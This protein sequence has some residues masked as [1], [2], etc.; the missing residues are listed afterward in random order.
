MVR[1]M[2]FQLP[3]M[4]FGR[5][6][7]R[8]SDP[9]LATDSDFNVIGHIDFIK[10]DGISGWISGWVKKREHDASL[11]I[12]LFIKGRSVHKNYLANL[13][14]IDL[15]EAE[16]G[17]GK[18][19]FD[20]A[21]PELCS[22]LDGQNEIE[23]RSSESGELLLRRVVGQG[24]NSP[25]QRRFEIR[26][27]GATS[28][29]L[30][31]W[32]VDRDDPASVFDL[33]VLI[34]D[35]FFCRTRNDQPRD[36]LKKVGKTRG[37][38]GI[39]VELPLE[40]LEKGSHNVTLL[41]PNGQTLSQTVKMDRE[42]RHAP[43]CFANVAVRDTAVIVPVYNAPDDLR[44]CIERLVAAHP[45]GGRDPVHRRRLARSRGSVPCWTRRRRGRTCGC[46][47]TSRT[48]ASRARSTAASPRPGPR[49]SSSSTATLG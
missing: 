15:R 47:G 20:F 27:D 29:Q 37:L 13:L 5:T 42:V 12:D 46:C 38:G 3:Q 45:R 26:I 21:S 23:I 7:Q 19:G 2:S 41:L 16:L 6:A 35:T 40:R 36:D 14:R 11:K 49:T 25:R 4:K 8:R 32:A 34:N 30:R 43:G 33:D 1:R 22:A 18:F 10:S 28:S 44:T 39:K 24:D 9:P 31:G 17:D 48:S